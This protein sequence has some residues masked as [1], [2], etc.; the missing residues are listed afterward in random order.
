MALLA[1]AGLAGKVLKPLVKKAA[2]F[3]KRQ[4]RKEAKRAIARDTVGIGVKA[5][6]FTGGLGFTYPKGSGR[7]RT[8]SES[9]CRKKGRSMNPTNVKALRRSLRRMEGFERIA[10]RYLKVHAPGSTVKGFKRQSKGRKR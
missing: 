3:P 9:G 1:L 7:G 10:R 4:A 8:T 2:G 6:G 5:G